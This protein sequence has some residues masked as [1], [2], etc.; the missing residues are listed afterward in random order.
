MA[1]Q[2]EVCEAVAW[3]LRTGGM[4]IVREGE[5]HVYRGAIHVH[6]QS[7]QDPEATLV[8]VMS[9]VRAIHARQEPEVRPT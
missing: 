1:G 5:V 9:E 3:L 2:Q 8:K 6:D 4:L 7:G